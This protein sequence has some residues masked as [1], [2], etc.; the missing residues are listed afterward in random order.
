MSM[1]EDGATH[2]NYLPGTTSTV[3]LVLY[4]ST[5]TQKQVRCTW[6]Q[7]KLQVLVKWKGRLLLHNLPTLFSPSIKVG[8]WDY[9]HYIGS[10]SYGKSTTPHVTPEHFC[11]PSLKSKTETV[12]MLRTAQQKSVYQIHKHVFEHEEASWAYFGLHASAPTGPRWPSSVFTKD[13]DGT[14]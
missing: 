14:S 6:I 13:P 1:Y 8:E 4:T 7:Q 3:E 9:C 10:C 5:V 2:C 11:G 12:T